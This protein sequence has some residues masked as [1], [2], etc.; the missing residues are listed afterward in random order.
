MADA[1]EVGCGN[2][3]AAVRGANRQVFPVERL[4]D[5]SC[6]DRLELFGIGVLKARAA[7]TDPWRSGI[8]AFFIGASAAFLGY[9]IGTLIPNALGLS[10]PAV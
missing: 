2:A 1:R 9:V 5:F 4:D 6:E 10:V 7:S 3:R 8:E